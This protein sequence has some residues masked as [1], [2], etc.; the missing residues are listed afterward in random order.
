MKVSRW[1]SNL[2]CVCTKQQSYKIYEAKLKK[3]KRQMHNEHFA[4]TLPVTDRT[5]AQKISNREFN[6]TNQQNQ[7][8]IEQYTSQE[9]ITHA[10]QVSWNTYIPRQTLYWPTNV[11]ELKLCKLYSSSTREKTRNQNQKDNFFLER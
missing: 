10:F 4:T 11:K 9:Q 8:F 1:H 2:K 6:T 7:R 5:A 3:I